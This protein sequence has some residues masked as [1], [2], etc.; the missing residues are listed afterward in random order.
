[1]P[2]DPGQRLFTLDEANQLLPQLGKLIDRMQKL[3]R[4]L[5]AEVRRA[6]YSPDDLDK[7]LADRKENAGMTGALDEISDCIA[8]IES[9]GCLFKGLDTGLVDFPTVINDE[10]A[11]LCWQYGEEQ[12]LYWHGLHEGFAGRH[13]IWPER[14]AKDKIN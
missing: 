9:H 5:L 12:V 14:V 2:R 6:G 13:P 3:Y 8:T 10:L 11:Y 7:L 4:S 1:M